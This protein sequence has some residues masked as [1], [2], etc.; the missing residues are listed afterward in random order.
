MIDFIR[1]FF[2][3]RGVRIFAY[4]LLAVMFFLMISSS[5]GDSA[6]MDER[7]HIAAGYSYLKTGDYRLNPEHPPLMKDLAAFPLLFVKLTFPWGYFDSHLNAQWD[8]GWKF[9]YD[10][11]NNVDLMLIL[12]RIPIMLVALILGFF[13]YKWARDLYDKK[14]SLLALIFYVFDANILAH[15]R[16]VTTDLG[17]TAA[18]FVHLYVLWRFFK[19]P[20]LKKLILA[21]ITLGIVLITKFFAALLPIIYILLLLSFA[22]ANFKNINQKFVFNKFLLSKSSIKKFLASLGYLFIVGIIGLFVMYLFYLPHVRNMPPP[23][24]HALI[25]EN[26]PGKPTTSL[27]QKVAN[28]SPALGQYFLGLEMVLYHSAGGHKAYLL[29]E[30]SNGWWYYY[31]V[32]FMI[33]TAIPLLALIIVSFIFWRRF[34]KREF[35]EA[36]FLLMPPLV[37]FATAMVGLDLGI[38]YLLPVYPFLIVFASRTINLI[39]F[40]SLLQKPYLK[41]KSIYALIFILLIFWQV[42]GTLKI[43]PY[44][45]SY[46]NEFIGGPKNGYK[47][48]TD[49]NLDWGQDLKRLAKWTKENNISNIKIDYFGS[50]SIDYYFG[51]KAEQWWSGRGKPKGYFAISTTFYASALG[52]I[53]GTNELLDSNYAWLKDYKPITT[54]GNSI[55]VFNITD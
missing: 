13:V 3:Q 23:V 26:L 42:I 49:S 38:R 12:S 45:L 46:F 10:Y 50:G 52:K 40:K 33:K 47:Y 15:S 18:L 14:A 41:A 43:H 39:D 35:L 16:L 24:Q 9:L 17:I 2:K 8:V 31:F 11:M 54:I 51:D 1:E 34:E 32:A 53:R 55:F 36:E 30:V 28:I 7:P 20:D 44:Y 27:I 21:G 19:N 6:T 29:G 25:E 4:L 48:L 5:L 22:F 37:F